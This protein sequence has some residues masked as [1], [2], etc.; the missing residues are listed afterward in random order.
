MSLYTYNLS[1]SCL[2]TF[3]NITGQNLFRALL[4]N[5]PKPNFSS[6]AAAE[7]LPNKIELSQ[8]AASSHIHPLEHPDYFNVANLFTIRD[9]FEARIHLGHKEG[10]LEDRMKPYIYGSRLG[11]LVFDLD[12]TAEHLR[13]AL[14]VTAHIALQGGIILFFCRSALNSHAVETAAKEC[15]EFAHTRYWRGGVFT[16]ANIQF[17]A[18]TRK[19]F[20]FLKN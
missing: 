5:S 1:I 3:L 19:F 16:N 18:V 2:L 8:L 11:H 14:N 4:K 15:D 7:P 17:G 12:Q 20:K 13:R 10:S 9:L 6:A